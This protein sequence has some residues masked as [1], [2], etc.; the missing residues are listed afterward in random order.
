V[1]RA[2]FERDRAKD[3]RLTAA[4]WRVMRF[5]RRQVRTEAGVVADLLLLLLDLAPLAVAAAG[6]QRA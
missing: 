3:A 2:A 5:T 1:T 6:A 4:G